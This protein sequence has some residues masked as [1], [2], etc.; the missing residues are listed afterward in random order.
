MKDI[1]GDGDGD[2][3]DYGDFVGGHDDDVGDAG[4]ADF[5]DAGSV[6]DYAEEVIPSG[7]RDDRPT[8]S[9]QGSKQEKA[10]AFVV[11]SLAIVYYLNQL[12]DGHLVS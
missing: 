1:P 3:Y 11:M 5:A 12:P 7:P 9:K 8:L 6:V 10:E 4:D 2:G